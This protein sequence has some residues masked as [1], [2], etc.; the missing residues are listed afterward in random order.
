MVLGE[1]PGRL[2]LRD[3]ETKGPSMKRLQISNGRGSVQRAQRITAA[4]LFSRS[5]ER[6][7]S[8]CELQR[9]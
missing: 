9:D 1:I 4:S 2:L 8:K 3:H 5:T 6:R 7:V